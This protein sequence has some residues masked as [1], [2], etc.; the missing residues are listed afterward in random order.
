M[1]AVAARVERGAD[2][3]NA[4]NARVY[5]YQTAL[6]TNHEPRTAPMRFLFIGQGYPNVPGTSSGSGIGTYLREITL[7]LVARGHPCDV[8]AWQVGEEGGRLQVS[9][10][11]K[12]VEPLTGGFD[13][14]AADRR[15]VTANRSLPT[16][17]S[18]PA[19]GIR[20]FLLAHAYWPLV[21]R[22]L[23]DSRD[24]LNLRRL[25]RRLD[26]EYHY[27]CIEI[28]SEEGIG[29]GVQR[30][31]AGRVLLRV[32]TTLQH[33]VEI[34]GNGEGVRW[35]VGG[36][37]GITPSAHVKERAVSHCSLSTV[38]CP[39]FTAS[40]PWK[41]RYRLWRERRSFHLAPRIITHSRMHAEEL[42]ARFPGI[43]EPAVVWHGIGGTEAGVRWE[44]GGGRQGADHRP[45]ATD[46]AQFPMH[47]ISDESV[48]HSP[49]FLL[50]GS[51]DRRKGFDRLRPILD[52]YVAAYGPCR[53]VIV[54]SGNAVMKDTLGLDPGAAG[55]TVDW[56]YDLDETQM[57]AEYRQADVYLHLARY[58]SFGLPLIEA[59]AAGVPVVSTRVGVAPELL[60][61]EMAA[62]LIDGDDAPGI[63]KVIHEAVV[64]RQH[65]SA[66]MCARHRSRFSRDVMTEGWMR[67]LGQGWQAFASNA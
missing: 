65:I 46:R 14:S 44:V 12:T 42:K 5:N 39:L 24:V 20:V 47:P 55:W 17:C 16:V 61:G 66:E 2:G 8:I 11:R 9:G 48:H 41:T 19:D 15:P 32:H 22:V 36:G 28:Q 27:D 34:K 60:D 43:A 4:V 56:R 67:L 1:K 49:T 51:M 35:K 57:A 31:C 54:T 64:N 7:G 10:G 13:S 37:A 53:A 21:E 40:P 29:I 6:T 23:P 59:A 58:E 45:Q 30:A 63:A 3:E 38:H 52:A 25:V 26:A 18:Q 50:V 62:C 33:M